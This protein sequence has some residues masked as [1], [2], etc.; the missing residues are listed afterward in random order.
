[1]T[2]IGVYIKR[3]G[4]P[5]TVTLHVRAVDGSNKP[6]GADLASG[7]LNG[8][9]FDTS[10][11]W[12][13][14]DLGAGTA[15]T[16]TVRYAII[17]DAASGNASNHADWNYASLTADVYYCFSGT[18]GTTWNAAATSPDLSFSTYS[19]GEGLVDVSSTIAGSGSA[20][21]TVFAGSVEIVEGT[22]TGTGSISGGGAGSAT[23]TSYKPIFKKRLIAIGNDRLFYESV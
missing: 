22:I 5:G 3:T 11:G 2:Q 12:Q 14:F 19:G 10:A 6:T 17:I 9:S 23:V 16:A 15:L 13:Y 8:N 7:T 18:S 21:G 4:N 20:S 1:V